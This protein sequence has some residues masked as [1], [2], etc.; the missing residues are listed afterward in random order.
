[1]IKLN[2]A[3]DSIEEQACAPKADNAKETD[4]AEKIFYCSE[5][6][7]NTLAKA[8]EALEEDTTGGDGKGDGNGAGQTSFAAATIAFGVIMARVAL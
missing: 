8:K 2:A 1:M 4:K 6:N 3:M 5:E 7:C